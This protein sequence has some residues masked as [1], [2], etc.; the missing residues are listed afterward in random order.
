M[1]KKLALIFV[2]SFALFVSQAQLNDNFNDGD[3]TTNPSW[4]SNPDDWLING[5]LQLQSNNAVASN[6]FYISTA[7]TLATSVQWEFYIKLDFNTSSANYVDVYL[8]A[9]AS[10]IS[11]NGTSG[12]FVR[13]GNTDDEICLYKKNTSGIITKIIDGT[14]GILNKSINA[15]KIK[16]TRG[17]DNNW[18]LF[19]DI[20]GTGNNYT[21]EGTTIDAT[22]PTSAFFGILIKQSTSS[23]FKKHYFDDITIE[24]FTPD[25]TPPVVQSATATSINTLDILFDEP[26]DLTT[27]QATGNYF[28]D[29][30]LASPATAIRD[31]AN[32]ALVH[33]TFSNNF[34]NRTT[35][36]INVNG[37]KDLSGN[38]IS[39]GLATFSFYIPQ[40]FDVIIDEIFAD[41]NPQVNLP[42]SEFI[43]L[44]NVSTFPINLSGWRLSD[45]TSV[46]FLPAFTLKPDSFVIVCST[47]AVSAYSS[48]GRTLG[49]S[50]FPSLND[51]SDIIS[52]SSAQ[53]NVIHAVAYNGSWYQNEL[54]KDGGW[55]LEMIDPKNF[56]SGFS[57]WKASDDIQGGT[58]GKKNS[59]DAV[60]VDDSAPKLLRASATDSVSI[61]LL[62]DEPLNSFKAATATSYAI[63]DAIGI[64][65][66]AIPVPPVF[67]K[68]TLTLAAPLLNN[69]VYTVTVKNVTDCAGN[70]IGSQN[71]SRVGI[72]SVA[73]SFDIVINEILFNPSPEAVDYV[74][75]YNRSTKT[76]D[77]KQLY[78]ASRSS[79]GVINS[80]HQLSAESIL[81]FPGDFMVI[82]QDPFAVKQKYITTNPDAF[83][84]VTGMP[85]FPDDKGD[86]II[87]NAQGQV[88]DEVKYS[89]KWHFALISNTEG[90]SL[91][92]I[93]Y[94]TPSI[95]SNF[96]SAATSVGYGTPGYKNSQYR[97]N[98]QVQGEVTISPEIFSPDNDGID[99]VA[100][101]NYNFPAAGF[102]TNITIF[103][104][105]GRPVRYL[106]RNALS[107]IKGSYV[108]DGLGEKLQK[109]SQG[110][111]IIFTEI[112]NTSGKKKQ[113]KNTIVLARKR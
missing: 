108:W 65:I 79:T 63:S 51:E 37:V 20:T 78:V 36:T 113:F 80:I 10:D 57:N 82:T 75:I 14:D 23:F 27:S 7:N 94:N 50:N 109:L 34:P 38:A 97:I 28:A 32:T 83:I 87:L 55:T 26:V 53:G 45:G 100:T 106:Q 92:R 52:L 72:A 107:G 18:V 67:D 22:Y 12:Y 74:E 64:P 59:V 48:F 54:K 4:S 62:F 66:N 2:F 24:T 39:N 25:V 95:Q 49:V 6:T 5:N 16:I 47:S 70:E 85:S 35:C 77:L 19:R 44:K 13:I 81:I 96:H 61:T 111:Y 69:K 110:I 30:N 71:T 84:Q 41:P 105:S 104:A 33:L 1:D 42:T 29:N 46:A 98:D 58:P 88:L 8:I 60:N 90:V 15:L 112:F 56:C 91:E 89:D 3:F 99:D 101:I 40:Q 103:D 17:A 73:D 102:V 68:V 31:A 11:A 76:I 86:V 93:D 43:E 21:S 9:S